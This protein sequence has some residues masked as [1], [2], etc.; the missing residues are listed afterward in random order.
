MY[1]LINVTTALLLLASLKLS[2]QDL[3]ESLLISRTDSLLEKFVALQEKVHDIHPCLDEYQPIAVVYEDSLLIFDF[4]SR[5]TYELVK[6][7]A[8]P[9]P[10]PEGIQASFPLS[11]YD[12]KPTCIINQNTL[13]RSGGFAT[14]L[15]EFIHCCQYNSVEMQLKQ[16]LE[17]Y[18][19]ATKENDYSWEITHPFPYND[20]VFIYYYDRYKQALKSNDIKS[21]KK[22]RAEIKDYL[23]PNDYEYMLWEEWKEGLARYVENKIRQR[24]EVEPNNYGSEKPYDRVAFYYSGGLLITQLAKTDPQLPNDMGGLYK[25]MKD[26]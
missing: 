9:F 7:T 26:F 24:M 14:I 19:G 22:L 2:A 8:Q 17:I 6:K 15:H 21:A 10:L 4:V 12:N 18:K 13:E 25:A 3:P 11:V 1:K 20:S 5:G 23:D 16:E